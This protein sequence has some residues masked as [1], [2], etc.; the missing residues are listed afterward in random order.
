ML[1][2]EPFII[3]KI[4]VIDFIK[5]FFIGLKI[6][7]DL[8]KILGITVSK[9]CNE[10]VLHFNIYE[11]DYQYESTR[12]D[13]IISTIAEAYFKLSG[14]KLDFSLSKEESLRQY[15]TSKLKKY[16]DVSY[17]L[18]DKLELCHIEDI[19]QNK[20]KKNI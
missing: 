5:F 17:T 8:E 10:F 19:I 7:V 14:K 3:W 1:Q 4:K 9:K 15:V 6:R 11:I 12:K 18:M 16:F 13:E 2:I 20:K